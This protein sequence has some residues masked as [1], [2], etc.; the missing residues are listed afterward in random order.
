M[1]RLGALSSMVVLLSRGRLR[2]ELDAAIESFLSST[3]RN[4]CG[5][6][7]DADS[8]GVFSRGVGIKAAAW[9]AVRFGHEWEYMAK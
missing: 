5:A 8:A 9:A 6:A 7:R 3:G 4:F 2:V 1:R